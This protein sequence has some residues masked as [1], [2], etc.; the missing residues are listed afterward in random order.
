MENDAKRQQTNISY[1]EMQAQKQLQAKK[2]FDHSFS[3]FESIFSIDVA[4]PRVNTATCS[5]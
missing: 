2:T 3:V 5:L 4:L 1:E